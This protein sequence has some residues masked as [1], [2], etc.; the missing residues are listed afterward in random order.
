MDDEIIVARLPKMNIASITLKVAKYSGKQ[1][2]ET[3]EYMEELMEKAGAVKVDP[4]YSFNIYHNPSYTDTNVHV[5]ICEV[6][7]DL[8][9][10]R[11][12]L[13]FS[14]L[15]PVDAVIYR[16]KGHYE[17]LKESYTMLHQWM[18]DNGFE[19]LD[20]PREYLINGPWNRT[21]P[22]NWLTEIQIPVEST[23]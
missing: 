7:E 17:D 3:S 19:Q 2:A 10:D 11:G 21:N 12:E 6:V 13:S 9:K 4:S 14:T 20:S 15:E 8:K 5:E 1:E 23:K 18:D 16:H 22:N